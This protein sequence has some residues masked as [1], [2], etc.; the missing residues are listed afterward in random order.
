MG[1]YT[2]RFSRRGEP[3]KYGENDTYETLNSKEVSRL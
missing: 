2:D 1:T 3:T